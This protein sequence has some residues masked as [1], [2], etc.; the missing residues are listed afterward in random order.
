[1]KNKRKI[2]EWLAKKADSPFNFY[3]VYFGDTVVTDRNAWA[4][5]KFSDT[6]FMNP[7]FIYDY[8]MFLPAVG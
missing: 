5:C 7:V 2:K 4:G 8:F 3:I 6:V 1:M